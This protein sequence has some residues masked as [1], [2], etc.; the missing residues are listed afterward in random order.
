MSAPPASGWARDIDPHGSLRRIGAILRRHF[1]LMRSSWTRVFD[2]MYWPILQMV[3]WGFMTVFLANHSAW[4]VRAGGLLIGAVLLWDV[5][6]RGQF[7]MTLSLLE[8]MWSRNLANLFVT[9]LRPVEYALAL[10]CLSIL[11]SLFGVLPAAL[12]A[13]P[14]FAYSVF[15]LGPQLVVFYVLLVMLGWSVGLLMSALL[16]RFGLAAESFAW[17]SIFVLAPISGVYYPVDTLPVWLRPVAWAL[18]STH[19]FE[20]M[21]AA[22][23]DG[24]FR[25]DLMVSSLAL[26]L[27]YFA[28][29]LAVF[30]HA[31]RLARERGQLLG[32][33]E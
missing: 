10:M 26:N 20:G 27:V 3:V 25:S 15:D 16:I 7:G 19:V 31:F 21:R 30:L 12:L 29:A 1:Y 23:I 18:P 6:V 33:G 8:E 13:I 11:R 14:L 9:P 24:V 17:A 22:M 5:L 28:V 4:V 32:S 2:L